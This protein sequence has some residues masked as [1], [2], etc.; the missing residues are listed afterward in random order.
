MGLI[1][2]I[3]KDL[4]IPEL[5]ATSKKEVLHELATAVVKQYQGLDEQTLYQIL[6]DRE[7]LGSTGIGDTVALPHGKI[8]GFGEIAICFGRSR[9]GIAYDA[10]DGKPAHLFFLL[11]APEDTATSYL[12]CLAELSRFLKNAQTRSRLMQAA[13]PNELLAIFA[14]TE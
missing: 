3:K 1:A 13:D 6:L 4:I 7:N 12:N 11:I 8:K 2:N 10:L 14:Q 5:H 9:D